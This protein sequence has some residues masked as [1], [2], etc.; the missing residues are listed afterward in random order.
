[1]ILNFIMKRIFRRFIFAKFNEVLPYEGLMKRRIWH[2]IN[3]NLVGILATIIFHLVLVI[4]F[5]VFKITS[6]QNLMDTIITIDFEEP[7]LQ[8]MPIQPLTEKDIKF[9]EYIADYLESERSNIPVNIATKLDQQISTDK[10]VN[11]LTEEM[12]SNRSDEMIRSEERLKE[13]EEMESEDNIVAEADTPVEK[14]PVVFKGKTNI[15]YS[16]KD[17]YYIRLP[18]PVYKC[19]GFG[20][21]EVQIF[22]DQK[23]YVVNAQVPN[24]GD[25][26][27]EICLAEAAK[28]AAMGTRFNSDFDAPIRQ[29]GTI[30]YHFQPQ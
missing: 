29:Q 15:Y 25:S 23:G 19:E 9:D 4:I 18:V 2:I 12:S 11:E 16:L 27:N 14:N 13:L 21:V 20:I 22:V 1:M 3:E 7:E 28:I 30:T 8:E 26:M 17:R 6:V 24:L 5:L 10:F